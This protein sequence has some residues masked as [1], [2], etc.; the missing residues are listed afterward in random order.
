MSEPSRYDRWRRRLA[1]VA[2][3]IALGVLAHDTCERKDKAGTPIVLDL[4]AARPS[5][6]HVRADAFV[7]GEPAGWFESDVVG[8][9]PLQFRALIEDRAIVRVQVTTD[10][11][12]RVIERAVHPGSD[13]VT[14]GL[15][16]D[17]IAP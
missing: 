14:L 16:R 5:V 9:R 15:E 12:L 10:H 3:L 11:G 13:P 17:L 7:A 4:G 1:P 8:D 2:L 6:R